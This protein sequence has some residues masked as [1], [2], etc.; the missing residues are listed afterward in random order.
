MCDPNCFEDYK[1]MSE[2]DSSVV[3]ESYLG[4][5]TLAYCKGLCTAWN[6]DCG[7]SCANACEGIR[8]DSNG[9]YLTSMIETEDLMY[10][11]DVAAYYSKYFC[12]DGEVVASDNVLVGDDGS[13]ECELTELFSECNYSGLS[14]VVFDPVLELDFIPQ[15]FCLPEYTTLVIHDEYDLNGNT[16]EYSE[17]L[18]CI[19]SIDFSLVGLSSTQVRK[20]LGK[21][22]A[23]K[24]EI[25][26]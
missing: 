25:R 20:V 21:K 24:V 13:V 6:D 19:D 8:L 14:A 11:D 26:K 7:E 10:T 16:A 18:S 2:S 23:F 4:E 5:Y 22:H 12:F 15:S 9:C 1:G 3:F 17:S